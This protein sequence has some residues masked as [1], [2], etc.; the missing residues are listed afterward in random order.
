MS[1]ASTSRGRGVG[2]FGVLQLR[3]GGKFGLGALDGGWV[4]GGDGAAFGEQHLDHVDGGGLADVVGLALEGEAEDGEMFSAQRPEG[5]AN[6]GEEALLLF[7]VDLFDLGEEAE[8]DA[9]LLGDGAEGGDVLGEAGA[10]V[11]DAGTEEAGADAAVEADAA[12]DLLDV[13][14]GG[15]AEVGDGVD[16]GDFEGEECVGGVL[17]DFGGLGGGEQQGR[18]GCGGA[19]AGDGVWRGSR[20]RR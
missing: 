19:G 10:T 15:L 18:R 14:A 20:R 13:C 16:E 11:A 3:A 2:V 6:L 4:V 1:R 12:G 8:V 7:G 9:E 17:D 5:G